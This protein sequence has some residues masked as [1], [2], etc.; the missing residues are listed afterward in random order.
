MR[1]PFWQG[2][3]LLNRF[4]IAVAL[5]QVVPINSHEVFQPLTLTVEYQEGSSRVVSVR[6]VSVFVGHRCHNPL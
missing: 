4:G 5:C 2:L 6:P 1:R 3:P